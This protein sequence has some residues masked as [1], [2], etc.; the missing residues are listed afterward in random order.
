MFRTWVGLPHP[1]IANI[2]QCVCTHP[3]DPMG[4]HLLDCVNGNKRIGAH[5]AIH[6]TFATIAWDVGFYEGWKLLHVLLSTTF[7]FFHWRINILLTKDGIRTLVG[8]VIAD[9]T[10]IYLLPQSCATQGF[11]TSN[12]VQTKERSYCNQHPTNQFLPL[13]IEVFGCLHKHADM[14]LHNQTNAIWSL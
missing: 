12:V 9:P 11:A 7:N 10:W 13:I 3:I 6:D 1:S 5:D 4:I 2:P 14:F 8:V